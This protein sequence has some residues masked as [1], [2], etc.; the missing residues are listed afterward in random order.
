M[1]VE[2]LGELSALAEE[3]LGLLL[4]PLARGPRPL[5]EGRLERPVGALELGL[6]EVRV[7]PGL[8][9]VEHARA[10]F[11]GVGD[12]LH[13]VVAGLGALAHEPRG[14]LVVHDDAVDGHAIADDADAGLA[15]WG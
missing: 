12:D 8:L 6:H 9:A 4:D 1:A 13:R 7:R 5:A 2:L 10:D 11:D 14:A 15:K 3:L